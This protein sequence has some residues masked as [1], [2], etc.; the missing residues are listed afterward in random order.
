VAVSFA[1]GFEHFPDSGGHRGE[2]GR[3]DAGQVGVAEQL[4]NSGSFG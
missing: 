3:R 4:Q 2:I 1:S